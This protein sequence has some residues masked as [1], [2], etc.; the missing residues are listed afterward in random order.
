MDLSKIKQ[1]LNSFQ[2][3]AA[4]EKIDYTKVYFKPKPGKYQIRIVPSKFD[5]TT[6]FKEVYFHY[7]FAKFPMLALTNWGE[8]DPIVDLS[9]QLRKTKDPENWKLAKKIEPKMRVFVPVVVRGEEQN[10]VRLWE[11]GKET[12]QQLLGIAAD[13]DYG[14]YTNEISGRDFT[15]DVVEDN[16]AGRKINKI[17]SIRIKPKESQITNDPELLTKILSEQ[18]DVLTL[19][20]K[21][22]F[23]DLS[24]TLKKWMGDLE[25]EKEDELPFVEGGDDEEDVDAPPVVA[26]TSTGKKT[27][28]D[29]FDA[30][31]K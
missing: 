9:Q 25:A 10:G 30:A 22:S 12:Y 7:G 20:R 2:K 4:R 1:K 23:E 28:V 6:P 8:K 14:D 13:E 5:K 18:P 16:V 21:P 26:T 19:N 27:N 15:I 17:S 31:F 3:P 11:F 24:E 29:K